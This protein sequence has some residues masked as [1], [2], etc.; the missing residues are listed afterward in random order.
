MEPENGHI[1]IS[2]G[3]LSWGRGVLEEPC[4]HI[5]CGQDREP[6]VPTWGSRLEVRETRRGGRS[7]PSQQ[8]LRTRQ[9]RGH[10]WPMLWNIQIGAAC[11]KAGRK[12]ET[13]HITF[14]HGDAAS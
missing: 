2:A 12:F 7:V 13:K 1:H 11:T 6:N 14:S 3:R 5:P 8:L 10:T 4:L 9:V